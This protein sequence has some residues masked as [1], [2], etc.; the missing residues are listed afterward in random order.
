MHSDWIKIRSRY[1]VKYLGEE[2]T[3][4]VIDMYWTN[5]KVLLPRI[6]YIEVELYNET[7]NKTFKMSKNIFATL[8]I[9]IL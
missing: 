1:K 5:L 3:C 7:N 9:S 8:V 6:P 2:I 4:K